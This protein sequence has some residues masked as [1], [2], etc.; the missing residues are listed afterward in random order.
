MSC[1][2]P[3]SWAARQGRVRSKGPSVFLISS[4]HALKGAISAKL[5]P[6]WGRMEAFRRLGQEEGCLESRVDYLRQIIVRRH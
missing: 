1:L 3:P 4:A 2:V 5:T 6:R